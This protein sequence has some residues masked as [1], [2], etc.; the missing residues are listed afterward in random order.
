MTGSL[1]SADG[2][3]VVGG[4]ADSS[5]R[6][7]D[8]LDD[9]EVAEEERQRLRLSPVDESIFP[10]PVQRPLPSLPSPSLSLSSSA[11][12]RSRC[13]SL[14]GHSGPVY[15]CSLSPDGSFLLSS[16]E[17]ATIRLWHLPT[18][19]N[20]V[21]YRGHQFPVWDVAFSPL[22][23]HFASAAQYTSTTHRIHTH[24]THPALHTPDRRSAAP[25]ADSPPHAV[26]QRPDR[27]AVVD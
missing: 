21:A 22:G 13:V 9:A 14:V 24:H 8:L 1:L 4:F 27:S 7:W 11:P 3:L 2:S 25:C 23:Y 5:L 20:L 10:P 17:D 12:P 26:R 6:V 15:G 19:A 18:A 16:S